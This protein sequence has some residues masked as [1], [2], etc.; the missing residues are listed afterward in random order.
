MKMKS[1]TKFDCEL[2]SHKQERP[3]Q[4]LPKW[5]CVPPPPPPPP[6]LLLNT[7]P[8]LLLLLFFF[9]DDVHCHRFSCT[10]AAAAVGV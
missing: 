3:C 2:E 10:F 9:D 5:R 6:R 8:P 1:F 7:R 4:K